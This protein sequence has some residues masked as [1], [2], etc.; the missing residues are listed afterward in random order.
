VNQKGAEIGFFFFFL[1]PGSKAKLLIVWIIPLHYY[2]GDSEQL[3]ASK[4]YPFGRQ[5]A[6]TDV[7]R[8]GLMV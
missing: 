2:R 5:V 7:K 4:R 1:L 8:R 6:E 3:S